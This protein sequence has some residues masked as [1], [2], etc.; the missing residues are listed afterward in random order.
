MRQHFRAV[1]QV[2][3]Q[4]AHVG[5]HVE[6]MGRISCVEYKIEDY[7]QGHGLCNDSFHLE[8]RKNSAGIRTGSERVHDVEAG[9]TLGEF[10]GRRDIRSNCI[11]AAVQIQIRSKQYL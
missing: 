10:M 4:I 9:V 6:D 7:M 8:R 5:F 1:Q 2:D 3:N 11:S